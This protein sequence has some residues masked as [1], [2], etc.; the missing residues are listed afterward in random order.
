[1]IKLQLVP[2]ESLWNPLSVDD[3][4]M[5]VIENILIIFL[6]IQFF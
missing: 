3:F 4:N 2:I 5:K 1:M 6:I